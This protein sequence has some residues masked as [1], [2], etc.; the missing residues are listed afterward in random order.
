M[1]MPAGDGGHDPVL[2]WAIGEQQGLFVGV[3]D[4]P[5]LQ[6]QQQE[7]LQDLTCC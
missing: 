6:Q 1:L 5:A 7:Q 2:P 4:L 3:V